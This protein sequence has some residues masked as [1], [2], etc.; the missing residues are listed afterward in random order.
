M[1]DKLNYGFCF[2]FFINKTKTYQTTLSQQDTVVLN[3]IHFLPASARLPPDFFF[4]FG[5]FLEQN[6]LII[7]FLP[8]TSSSNP[9]NSCVWFLLSDSLV[10]VKQQGFWRTIPW[11]QIFSAFHSISIYSHQGWFQDMR[12]DFILSSMVFESDVLKWLPWGLGG[13]ACFCLLVQTK[14]YNMSFY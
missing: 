6:L 5:F 3:I 4:F 12:T 1:C 14:T 7:L 8:S 9:W 11:F 10:N 13:F 2:F